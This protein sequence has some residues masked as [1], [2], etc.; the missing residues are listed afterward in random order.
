MGAFARSTMPYQFQVVYFEAT[1]RCNLRCPMC[2]TGSNEPKKLR[3]S[4]RTELTLEEIR[5][6]VLIP[7]RRLGVHTIG[8]SGGEFLVRRDA[9]DLL[10]L[11][12]DLGYR[13]SV[14]SNCKKLTRARLERIRD[15]TR[16]QARI[17]V[18]LNALDEDNRQTRDSESDRTLQVL[19]DCAD[20]GLG[21]HVVITIGKYN[22]RSFE[23]TV[24]F[25]VEHGVAFNRS[26]LVPR[27]SGSESFGPLAFDRNDLEKSFHPVLRRNP[28]G[29]VSYTPYFLSPELHARVSGGARNNT[30]PRNPSI[31]CWVGSWLT[32]NA[33]GDV[34]FC[35]VLLDAL[36]A[37]N[38]REKPIDELVSSSEL[39]A[40]LTDR[41]RLKGRCGRCRYQ[42]TCG[43]CRAM[44]L[45]HTGDYMGEDPTCF[46][47]PV[48][49]S[50][51]SE[52]E[53]QTNRVFMKYLL[54]ARAA[55]A[56]Q[57]LKDR[58]LGGAVYAGPSG[59]ADGRPAGSDEAPGPEARVEPRARPPL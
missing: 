27:G 53:E 20:L 32:L 23:R 55:G 54:M 12:V 44:A 6:R 26:P 41:S 51:V 17:V 1:R 52:H 2:M 22:T 15:V 19:A 18:G 37:G 45:Y 30:V 28:H 31:G 56:Y 49:R 33:E 9:L 16:G 25:C 58:R 4:V 48:D 46:F 21:R 8:W 50:T 35:P 38:V 7:A 42:Y 40:E 10:R 59:P 36:H 14:L 3:Q 43:G 11:T 13:C 39:F 29:Y 57:P 47:D 24:E 5:D 34:S